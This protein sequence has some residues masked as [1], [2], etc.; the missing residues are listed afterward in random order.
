MNRAQTKSSTVSTD[1]RLLLLLNSTQR[2]CLLYD[3]DKMVQTIFYL[4]KYQENKSN[5]RWKP[6]RFWKSKRI[7][8]HITESDR[9]LKHR[10]SIPSGQSLL[11]AKTK[12]KTFFEAMGSNDHII[13]TVHR[14]IYNM[15]LWSL[16]SHIWP[17]FKHA[18]LNSTKSYTVRK[19]DEIFYLQKCIQKSGSYTMTK[20]NKWKSRS[21]R[22]SVHV[23]A[24]DKGF[25]HI[26]S[27]PFSLLGN[28]CCGEDKTIGFVFSNGAKERIMM[29]PEDYNF[30]RIF[31]N[32]I[33]QRGPLMWFS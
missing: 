24:F 15:W 25:N 18:D 19:S 30:L 23:T 26:K 32:T 13:C 11:L 21:K 5:M 27:I 3:R 6:K 4:Q 10:K 12:T 1:S 16:W 33:G 20:K 22:I 31:T 2:V 29:G 14:Y 8:L 28:V 9:G 7:S 17:I